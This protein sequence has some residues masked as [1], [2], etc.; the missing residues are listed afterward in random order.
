[1]R[2]DDA[3]GMTGC[4]GREAHG[5]AVVFID[6]RIL[7][8]IIRFGE[9]LFVIQKAFRQ[10]AATVRNNDDSFERNIFAKFFIERE[11]DVVNQKKPVAGLFGDASDFMRM[12]TKIQSMQDATGTRNTE[13]GFQVAGM[14]PHHGGDSVTRPQAEFR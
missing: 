2:I 9:Q 10:G 14:I 7:K 8:I 11:E 6:R 1:V 13:E 3:L 12:E 4:A 5:R